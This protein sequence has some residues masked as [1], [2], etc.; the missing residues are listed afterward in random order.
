M[1]MCSRRRAP[2]LVT[3][4][5]IAADLKE[6]G[7]GAGDVVMLHASVGSI[8]WIVGGP[9][10]VLEAFQHVLGEAGTLL[11]YV[12]WDG[13]PYDVTLGM[14]EVPPQLREV[15]P[16]F[17]PA[18]SHAV[19][20]WGVLGE[21]LRMRPGARRSVHPDSSFVA[22]GHGAEELTTDHPLQ[23]GMGPGSPLG[24]L[25]AAGGKVVL[26]GSP[27]A[28]VTLLHYAEHL[29]DVPDKDVVRYHAPILLASGEKAWVAIEEFNTGGEGCL[30][31]HG[32]TDMFEAIV[33]D[34]LQQGSGTVGRVG[35]APSYLFDAANL[36]EFAVDWIEER[37]AEPIE[38]HVEVEIE[39]ASPAVHHEILA[40]FERMA[41]ETR[42]SA[43][44]KGRLST[45][46]DEF[47]E[48]PHRRVF[49]A[50]VDEKAVGVLVALHPSPER[51]VL[52]QAYVDPDYRR[53]GILRELEIDAAGYLRERG[54]RD[55]EL[56]VDAENRAARL[57][58]SSLGYSSTVEYMKRPL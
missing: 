41:E 15:W 30:P 19:R 26:L 2:G 43:E 55:V 39:V 4:E 12:G 6:L 27:L 49:V 40:L 54:C 20:E 10:R 13:S 33:R 38:R 16:A 24:K 53:R 50:R 22:V 23:Y 44:S 31:W 8:G 28:N 14:P 29:A 9:D 17:D 21:Y 45:R 46:V 51:G 52:E 25:C 56:H 48:D 42:G 37:Y 11:M 58:W 1:G 57:A 36:V 7:L 32:P 35:A 3:R 34:Y 5:R 47:L 18:N